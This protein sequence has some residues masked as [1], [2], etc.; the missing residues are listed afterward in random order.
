MLI[1]VHGCEQSK[2][3]QIEN[4]YVNFVELDA[5]LVLH[6]CIP[7]TVFHS[8]PANALLFSKLIKFS[9][10]TKMHIQDECQDESEFDH[11]QIASSHVY[12]PPLPAR[13][14]SI[15]RQITFDF[16]QERNQALSYLI[17]HQTVELSSVVDPPYIL[18]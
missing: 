13:H 10:A 3:L 15:M 11:Q 12:N 7:F 14:Y 5:V 6:F 18:S 16:V 4:L 9:T 17:G 2:G 1:K 8:I